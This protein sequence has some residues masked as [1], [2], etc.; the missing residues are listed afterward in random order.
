M[1][2]P[3][4]S[5]HSR[6]TSRHTDLKLQLFYF[7]GKVD[8]T[9]QSWSQ[10]VMDAFLK[11]SEVKKPNAAT[12]TGKAGSQA[13][14]EPP[15]KKVKLEPRTEEVEESDD[16]AAAEPQRWKDTD[17]DVEAH[18]DGRRPTDVENA[19]LPAGSDEDAIQEYETFKLSQASDHGEQKQMTET[20]KPAWVRGQ[21]SIYVDAFNL[22]LDT[23]LDEESG[24][25]DE[26]ELNVFRQWKHLSYEAQFL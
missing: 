1:P 12:K 10:D 9:T 16:S 2:T 26:K 15:A 14:E 21:S 18:R 22:A 8:G 25:F 17:D 7:L 3:C 4:R 24:L 19:L 23:V 6:S 20:P 13:P 11:R 5:C